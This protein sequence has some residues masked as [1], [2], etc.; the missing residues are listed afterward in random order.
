MNQ[1]P[2]TNLQFSPKKDGQKPHSSLEVA[3]LCKKNLP[4]PYGDFFGNYI[5]AFVTDSRFI[6]INHLDGATP[7]ELN[8]IETKIFQGIN[9]KIKQGMREEKDDQSLTPSQNLKEYLDNWLIGTA[10][11]QELKSG[12]KIDIVKEMQSRIAAGVGYDAR[13]DLRGEV[14]IALLNQGQLEEVFKVIGAKVLTVFRKTTWFDSGVTSPDETKEDTNQDINTAHFHELGIL[15]QQVSHNLAPIFYK[16]LL[17]SPGK[18]LSQE[19][20]TI[21]DRII[22]KIKALQPKKD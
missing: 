7:A 8:N 5:H 4:F 17:H 9:H 1:T 18:P 21:S 16:Q 13:P 6:D 2:E 10:T 11:R 19:E 15:G 3:E 22:S 12:S 14:D 20:S